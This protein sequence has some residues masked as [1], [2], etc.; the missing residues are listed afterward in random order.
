MNLEQP[1]TQNM[2][3]FLRSIK[4]IA[5]SLTAIQSVVSYICLI[6]YT[7]NV[8]DSNYYGFVD[9]LTHMPCMLT[10]DEVHNKLLVHGQRV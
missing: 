10:L 3:D 8:L 9:A 1:K 6:Q 7:L 5:D 4:N 2:D